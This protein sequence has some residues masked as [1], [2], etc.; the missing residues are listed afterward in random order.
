MRRAFFMVLVVLLAVGKPAH[1]QSPRQP[2]IVF[3]MA[4]DLGINDLG[5]YGRKDHRTP[6]LDKL[7]KRGLRFTSAYAAASI[8]SPTRASIMTGQ[9][10]AKLRITTFLPGRGDTVAQML[11]HP[12][13][14]QQLPASAATIAE[15]LR[16][17]GYT[18]ACIGKWHLGGKGA[19]PT[20]R[21][22]DLY[23]PGKAF[24]TPSATEG[25]KGE[26]DLTLRAE[27][28]LDDNKDRPFFLYLSH[29]NPHVVLN[30]KKELIA[31]NKDAFNPT[32]AAMVETLDDCVGR[33]VAK[34]EALNL[35]ENTIFIFTSDNGGLH[36]LETALTP[37]TFHRLF[38]GGKG[39]LYEGGIRI[40]L[41]VCWP[42]RIPAGGATDVPVITTDW[43]PTFLK[44]AGGKTQTKFEGIDLTELLLKGKAP[45]PRDLFWHQPHYTNQG[46]RPAGAIR[47]GAWKLI[48]QYETGACALYN[49][50]T[51]LGETKDLAAK[52]PGR[53][54]DL[55]GKLEKWRRDVK[56][57]ENIANPSFNGKLWRKLYQ[58]V[59]PTR[60]PFEKSAAAMALKLEPWRKLM[61]EV[62][63]RPKQKKKTPAHVVPGAGAVLLHARNAKVHGTKLRYES[64]PYKDTLGF[65]VNQDDW[66]EWTFAVPQAGVF[67][68][69]VLQAAGKGS[70]GAE[71]AIA[72]QGKTLTMKVEATGHFQRFIPRTAGTLTLDAGKTTL[73][74]RAKSKPGVAVMDLRR[75]T[76]RSAR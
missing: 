38:R 15:L 73:S 41:I 42:G 4:D 39:F 65:W 54:A 21:G 51:D 70:G 7:A 3:I 25:G 5:C 17:L 61:N 50:A 35:M 55:R 13:I 20:E 66:V 74:V 75:L 16:A 68:V 31:K 30:A 2:N 53:V 29:N 32:Y 34:L 10:P 19:L 28:F 56:A 57:Q 62:V 24:T 1:A 67:E 9:S 72:V 52:E 58:D 63:V 47:A 33:V 40:P 43:A 36:V 23:H 14:N 18:T 11:L 60:L 71:I 76:L 59:D 37:A 69:E 64:P 46:G 49:L 6:N 27:K 44:L 12:D 48:E 22:F 8:C 26:Y 45:S